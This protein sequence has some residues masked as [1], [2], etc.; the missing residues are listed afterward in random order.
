MASWLSSAGM[1]LSIEDRITISVYQ[2]LKADPKLV[3]LFRSGGGIVRRH[4]H[5]ALLGGRAPRLV[6]GS[7]VLTE[8]RALS[9]ITVGEHRVG[10]LVEF[11]QFREEL[12]DL[13]PSVQSVLSH[14]RTVVETGGPRVEGSATATYMLPDPL[15]ARVALNIKPVTWDMLGGV[16][17][18][19]EG[20]VSV[21]YLGMEC[22]VPYK[23]STADRQPF[24]GGQPG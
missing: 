7:V 14:I 1:R 5:H 19:V 22:V 21:F 16:P 12:G 24:N 11:E 2:R 8:Q 17:N 23:V 3:L 6:V 4:V 9:R 13:E 10:I 15:D 18:N 20:D